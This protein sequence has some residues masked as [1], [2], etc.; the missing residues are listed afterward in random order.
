MSDVQA[1]INESQSVQAALTAAN[2]AQ[3]AVAS[4]ATPGNELTG[5]HT[6]MISDPGIS[7]D[8]TAPIVEESERFTTGES[9]S[10]EAAAQRPALGNGVTQAGNS[11]DTMHG[12]VN[13]TWPPVFKAR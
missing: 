10:A 1:D 9:A 8:S 4:I 7:H 11:M 2:E 13:S 3:N 5:G 6:P 12:K